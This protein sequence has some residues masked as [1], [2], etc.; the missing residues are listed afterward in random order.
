MNNQLSLE[1]ELKMN[2]GEAKELL[3]WLS[4]RKTDAL[5]MVRSNHDEVLQRY[6]IE[7]R[8]INDYQ[9]HR[10][11]LDL[12]AKYLDG[13]DPLKFAIEKYLTKEERAS[14]LWLERD[15]EYKIGGVEC[16]AHGDKGL[17]GA[18]A[19]LSSLERAYRKAVVGHSHTA[20]ILRDIFR[21]GTS[22][23]LKQDY[24]EGPSSWTHTHC[25]IYKNGTR[26]LITIINGK[27]RKS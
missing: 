6:L 5:V 26:Q 4:G 19:S 16:G 12:A 22:S 18:K 25:S 2:A 21:V 17:N 10:L 27:W 8:Y 9:N 11:A 20:A 23:Y 1:N 7:G 14:I 24:N 3:Q 13:E 15:E